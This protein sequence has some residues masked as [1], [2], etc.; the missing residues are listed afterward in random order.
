MKTWRKD[1]LKSFSAAAAS[2]GAVS[3]FHVVGITPEAPT[4]EAAFQGTT[5]YETIKI[6]PDRMREMRRRLNTGDKEQV[7]MVL[8][9]CP[10]LSVDEIGQIAKEIEGKK[11]CEGTDFWIQTSHPIYELAKMAGYV[12]VLEAAGAVLVRDS[13]LMEME[14]N[15]MWTGKH[16][17]TNS[18]KAAQYAPAINSVKIT[19]ADL[20]GCVKAAVTGKVPEEV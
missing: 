17:V 12:D 8:T 3:L 15:G 2:G 7:D 11:V 1:N 9:G 14:Y 18:G 19:M 6:T 16:F 5:D 13:C 20:K 4:L 10:H